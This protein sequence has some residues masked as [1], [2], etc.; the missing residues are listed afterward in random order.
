VYTNNLPIYCVRFL[1]IRGIIGRKI[2]YNSQDCQTAKIVKFIAN[3][4]V[5]I[6]LKIF[7]NPILL[8]GTRPLDTAN[9]RYAC[10]RL[11]NAALISECVC[12]F[13]NFATI[14]WYY[15]MLIR[16]TAVFYIVQMNKKVQAFLT[17]NFLLKKI[18]LTQ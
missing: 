6:N 4:W 1:A 14:S 5:K 9:F 10:F 18:I 16:Q 7:V 3:S 11:I 12:F 13:L 8:G 15:I 17:I 2:E